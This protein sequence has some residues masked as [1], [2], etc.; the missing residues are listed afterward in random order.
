MTRESVSAILSLPK[1]QRLELAER[2][3][4]SVADEAT[5]P[6]PSRHKKII[7][8]RLEAYRSGKSQPMTHAE[9]MQ[10]VRR[11]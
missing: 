2:L 11:S 1:R 7:D 10:R 4:L 8:E 5:M 9:L 3:W 6:V